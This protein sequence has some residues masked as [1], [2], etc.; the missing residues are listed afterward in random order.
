ML[1]ILSDP[2]QTGLVAVCTPEEMPVSET[3]EL[4]DRVR[5]ETTVQLSAVVVNRVL[6]E[7]FGQREEEVFEQLARA[8]TP[9]ALLS[10]RAG[11]RWRPVLEAARLAVTMRRTRPTHSAAAGRAARRRAGA[12]LPVPVRS[13]LGLRTTRQVAARRWARSS[14]LMTGRLRGVAAGAAHDGHRSVA[15]D[16]PS[17]QRVQLLAA[18]EIV[19]AC[20]PGRGGQDHHR[21]R[22]GRHGRRRARAAR[23]WCSP[24]TRPG[25]WPTRSG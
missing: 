20:G 19:I 14:G 13:Q 2:R 22:S 3:L 23:C 8:R 25:G 4:A 12:L 11:G 6:P 15:N 21:G 7:L 5:E 10:E 9:Q 16:Q 17:G 1:D 24:S 18:K